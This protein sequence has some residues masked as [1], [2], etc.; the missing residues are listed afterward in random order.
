MTKSSCRWSPVH[1]LHKIEKKEAWFLLLKNEN[2]ADDCW[3]SQSLLRGTGIE[4][5]ILN[6]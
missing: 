5:V 2:Y 3:Y 1:L 6:F 4:I